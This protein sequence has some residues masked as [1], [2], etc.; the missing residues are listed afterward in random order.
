MKHLRVLF[1]YQNIGGVM[2]E[3]AQL[4]VDAAVAASAA[5]KASYTTYSCLSLSFIS[6]IFNAQALPWLMFGLALLTFLMNLIFK[7]RD[8]KRAER[9]HAQKMGKKHD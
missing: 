3:K 6:W 2:S 4:A 7:Y 9:E 1:Y 8:D 5:S